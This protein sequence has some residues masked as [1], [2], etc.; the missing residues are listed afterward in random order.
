MS[1]CSACGITG[2]STSSPSAP[3]SLHVP[4]F[5]PLDG[6]ETQL[7]F[8]IPSHPIQSIGRPSRSGHPL[9]LGEC[10]LTSKTLGSGGATAVS[11][12]RSVPLRPGSKRSNGLSKR[13]S[14]S[15][16]PAYVIVVQLWF[17]NSYL[18]RALNL[19]A[20]RPGSC[21]TLFN[22]PCSVFRWMSLTIA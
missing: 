21:S 22:D 18:L 5:I 8:C 4:F 10:P 1:L 17:P 13:G 12:S 14:R 20:P 19:Q 2:E 16:K 11:I 9:S 15:E 3:Q 7:Y 6:F